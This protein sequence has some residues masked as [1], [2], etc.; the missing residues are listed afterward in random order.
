MFNIKITHEN[1]HEK[2][3]Y[4]LSDIS[5][6]NSKE[7]GAYKDTEPLTYFRKCFHNKSTVKKFFG[8][9]R[10]NTCIAGGNYKSFWISIFYNIRVSY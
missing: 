9:R 2:C 8:Y 3:K 10:Y 4:K 6:H 5:V 7:K 1:S